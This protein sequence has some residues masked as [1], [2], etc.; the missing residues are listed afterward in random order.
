MPLSA[1]A[2]CPGGQCSPNFSY[3]SQYSQYQYS[4]PYQGNYF[5]YQQYPT[6]RYNQ[7]QQPLRTYWQYRNSYNDCPRYPEDA[8]S[9]PYDDFMDSRDFQVPYVDGMGAGRL[10]W[11]NY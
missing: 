4:Q 3:Q 5:N 10:D 6:Q 2:Q 9:Q 8:Y 11:Y 1:Y 7:Y